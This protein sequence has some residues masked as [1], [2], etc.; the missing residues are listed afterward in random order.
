[1]SLNDRVVFEHLVILGLEKLVEV[2]IFLGFDP[3]DNPGLDYRLRHRID[4][5]HIEKVQPVV[6]DLVRLDRQPIG[7]N[8][9]KYQIFK[10]IFIVPSF[11][12]IDLCLVL[13]RDLAV[14]SRELPEELVVL[15]VVGV[16][17][18]VVIGAVRHDVIVVLHTLKPGRYLGDLLN[19]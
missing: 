6:F 13:R 11:L 15:L 14:F 5:H 12:K 3:G 7:W 4:D 10:A 2:V 9:L 18:I 8:L 19:I 1:M 17:R 16:I